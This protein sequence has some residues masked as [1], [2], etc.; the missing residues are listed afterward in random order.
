MD[1][2]FSYNNDN[3]KSFHQS[4]FKK[5]VIT[6]SVCGEKSRYHCRITEDEGLAICRN[7]SS[8]NPTKDGNGWVH[9]LNDSSIQRNNEFSEKSE[10]NVKDLVKADADKLNEVYSA[11]LNSLELNELHSDDLLNK[12]GLSETTIAQNLYVSVPSFE[13]RFEVARKLAEYF[14][15]EGVPGFYLDD[16]QWALNMTFSGFYV[17]YRDEQG[18]IIGL[19]IRQDKNV[20][21]KYMWLSSKGKEKGCSSGV[22]L[23][24]VNPELVKESGKVFITEGALKADIIAQYLNVGVVAMGGVNVL[25][26]EMLVDY[27]LEVF[28]DLKK[29]ILAFD[30]DWDIKNEVRKALLKLLDVLK[31]EST[32]EVEAIIWNK[33]SGK[34]L[35]DVLWNIKQADLNFED[36]TE[37][38]SE[39]QYQ[40]MLTACKIENTEDKTENIKQAVDTFGIKWGDFLDLELPQTEKVMFGIGRG[41]VGLMIATTNIGKTTIALNLALSAGIGKGFSPLFDENYKA[42]KVMYIDGESTKADLRDDIKTMLKSCSD[43]EQEM[44]KNN[45][46]IV[47]DEELPSGNLGT[48]PLDLVNPEHLK[49]VQEKAIEFNPDLI[50]VDTLSAL[51]VME[52]ENDNAKVKKEVIQPLKLLAKNADA[53]VLLLHHSGKASENGRFQAEDAFKGRGASALGALSRVVLNLKKGIKGEAEKIFLSCSK[54]KGEKFDRLEIKLNKNTRWFEVIGKDSASS[55]IKVDGDYGEIIGFVRNWVMTKGNSVKRG[56]IVNA[57]KEKISRPKVDRL[58][59]LALENDDLFQPKNGLYSAVINKKSEMPLAE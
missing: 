28:P 41:N 49:A 51:T 6:C 20:E 45:L 47:C 29:V 14:N 50:I 15:L 11:L 37:T 39:T 18:R 44:V 24:F 31:D 30:M 25:N 16:G 5:G 3:N 55:E 4:Q 32:L 23:H 57:F 56:V 33:D 22:P 48:E 26:P 10:N 58:L 36:L 7:V 21:N 54:V 27:L 2:D 9:I 53:G 17:P 38:V 40:E 35:D 12:R 34:G 42:R 19:Q 52:D 43:S 13:S 46:F 59:R 1:L 8:D